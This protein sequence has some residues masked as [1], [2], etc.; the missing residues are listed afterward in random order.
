MHQGHG[1]VPTTV[2]Q[3]MLRSSGRC[4]CVAFDVATQHSPTGVSVHCDSRRQQRRRANKS[5]SLIP[6]GDSVQNRREASVPSHGPPQAHAD[7]RGATLDLPSALPAA[8]ALH[9]AFL[10]PARRCH[11]GEDGEAATART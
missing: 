6:A 4:G 8:S 1:I 3:Q 9:A 5:T 11:S 2:F 10:Y 7:P